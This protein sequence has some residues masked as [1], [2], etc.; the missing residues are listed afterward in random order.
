MADQFTKKWQTGTTKT[1]R[2]VYI[3]LV[4]TANMKKFDAYRQ[5]IEAKRQCA[6]TGLEA[7]NQ[8]RRWHGTR[9]ACNIGD[10]GHMTLCTSTGCALCSIIRSSFSIKYASDGL[11]VTSTIIDICELTNV[12]SFGKGIYTSS[13]SSNS[14][15]YSSNLGS[16]PLKAMLLNKVIV[17]RG[18]KTSV[19]DS[20]LTAPPSG[21]DS[22]RNA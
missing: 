20:S 5:A 22:V 8:Q 12:L 15:G 2:Y 3:V 13:T 1:V 18:H 19:L 21:Y 4:S 11:Y 6:Q 7:G 17:G 16:S 14:D 10:P 9:R